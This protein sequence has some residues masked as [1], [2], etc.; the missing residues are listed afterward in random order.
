MALWRSA[1]LSLQLRPGVPMGQR[2][3]GV[4]CL[5]VQTP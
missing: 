3:L 4:E 5:K 1:L 2:V